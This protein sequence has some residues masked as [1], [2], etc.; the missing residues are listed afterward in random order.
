MR[1]FQLPRLESVIIVGKKTSIRRDCDPPYVKSSKLTF[2]GKKTSIRRDCDS[3]SNPL[4]VS[5]V[6]VGKK[7]SI[8]RDC[9]GDLTSFNKEKSG[10]KEDLN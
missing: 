8:R 5:V 4:E 9:D 6:S 10:R 3:L 2:V 7:T 1:P